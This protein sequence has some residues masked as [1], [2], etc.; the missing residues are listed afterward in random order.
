MTRVW[1]LA[2]QAVMVLAI[3]LLWFVV[4]G[5]HYSP[6]FS[7]YLAQRVAKHIPVSELK[8]YARLPQKAS[9]IPFSTP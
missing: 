9:G 6:G 4:Y 1:K 7:R 3:S 8:P 5:L 2:Q